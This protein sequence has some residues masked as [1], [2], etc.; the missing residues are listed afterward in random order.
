MSAQVAELA[1][2]GVERGLFFSKS[3]DLISNIVIGSMAGVAPKIFNGF[4]EFLLLPLYFFLHLWMRSNIDKR[5]L[6]W[7]NG[8]RTAK[9]AGSSPGQSLEIFGRGQVGGTVVCVCVLWDVIVDKYWSFEANFGMGEGKGWGQFEDSIVTDL[10][11]VLGCQ[12]R[13][14]R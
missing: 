5:I 2:Q 11:S 7:R 12:C 13:V 3:P 10:M 6:T 14:F 9:A 4:V 1:I 8:E